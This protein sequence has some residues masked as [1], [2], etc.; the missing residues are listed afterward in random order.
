[1][2]LVNYS[3]RRIAIRDN[4]FV[5]NV[6]RANWMKELRLLLLTTSI[7]WTYHICSINSRYLTLAGMSHAVSK[8][9]FHLAST[10]KP[11][12][13]LKVSYMFSEYEMIKSIR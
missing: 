3:T 7:T 10:D 1:M 11:P 12:K 13:R 2:S 4:D 5:L 9:S 6:I 8:R